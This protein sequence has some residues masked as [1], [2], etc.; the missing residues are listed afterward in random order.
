MEKMGKE[1][2]R[3]RIVNQGEGGIKEREVQM[4]EE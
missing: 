2:V 4:E 3:E 1:E